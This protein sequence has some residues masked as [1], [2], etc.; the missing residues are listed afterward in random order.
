MKQWG[1]MGVMACQG[2]RPR[3]RPSFSIGIAFVWL[4]VPGCFRLG[5]RIGSWIG[6]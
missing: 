5:E 2:K 6:P 4:V 3:R 1:I